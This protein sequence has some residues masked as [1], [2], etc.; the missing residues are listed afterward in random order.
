MSAEFRCPNCGVT[1]TRYRS[2]S[3][4]HICNRCGHEWGGREINANPGWF[5]RVIDWAKAHPFGTLLTLS[6]LLT[7][8][9]IGMLSD[10]TATAGDKTA[11]WVVAVILWIITFCYWGYK[12]S[13]QNPSRSQSDDNL[14]YTPPFTLSDR[15]PNLGTCSNCGLE[16]I[17]DANY[18]VRCGTKV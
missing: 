16:Q 6:V 9:A 4:S 1:D 10:A 12:K 8:A 3:G 18:C 17:D 15:T 13:R 2:T 11:T 7:F 5:S 14:I